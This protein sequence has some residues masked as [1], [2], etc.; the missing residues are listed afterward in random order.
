MFSYEDPL[1]LGKQHAAECVDKQLS[2]LVVICDTNESDCESLLHTG[3]TNCW[4]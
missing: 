4:K 3:G 2:G 1:C